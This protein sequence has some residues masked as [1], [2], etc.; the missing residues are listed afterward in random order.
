MYIM[1][2]S[3][4]D[5][6]LRPL[7]TEL[8]LQG[9]SKH[10]IA[11]YL[12]FNRSFLEFSAK[13]P[14]SITEIDI[15]SYLGKLIGDGRSKT[16]VNL[17]RSALVYFYNSVLER[18]LDFTKIKTPK[19]ERSLPV[20]LTAPEVKRLIEAS[21][22][23]KS[24]LLIKLLYASGLRISECCNLKVEDLE[25]EQKIA[26]VRS[27][28]GG[29]DRMVILSEALAL[30]LRRY[31]KHQSIEKGHILQNRV[32]EG[33]S[34]RN[35]QKIIKKT[36]QIAKINKEVTPHKLRHSFATHLREGGTDL[37]IIQELLGHSSIRTTEIYTHVSSEEKRKVV[38]PLDK[39]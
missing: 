39:L 30:E 7:I 35:A 34:P 23:E 9:A 14:A 16:S 3:N 36:A 24:K 26:W 1:R 38:S 2:P 21:S 22:H 28:K 5:P 32:G 15:K 19:I 13:D 33:M 6:V 37:R 31:L 18:G 29:K 17:A 10:T 20:V 12:R 8:Q 25:L 11:A 4:E 27:G